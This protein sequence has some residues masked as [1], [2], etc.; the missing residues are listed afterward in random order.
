MAHDKPVIPVVK[1]LANDHQRY[2]LGKWVFDIRR[3]G[4]DWFVYNA[5]GQAIFGPERSAN[6]CVA[7]LNGMAGGAR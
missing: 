6:A 3:V 1:K 2:T 4:R 5:S 7:M